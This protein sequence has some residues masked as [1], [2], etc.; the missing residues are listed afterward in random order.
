M[1]GICVPIKERAEALLRALGLMLPGKVMYIGG[2]DTLPLP[3]SREEESELIVRL[4]Q[5][6]RKARNRLI[7]H[8]LRLVAHIVKNG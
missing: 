4:G 3:L 6:D 5:G 7:E 2:S 1:K 8:N